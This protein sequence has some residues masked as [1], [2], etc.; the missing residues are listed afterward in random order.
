MIAAV[1]RHLDLEGECVEGETKN[2]PGVFRGR[3]R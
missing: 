2:A 3:P 1:A